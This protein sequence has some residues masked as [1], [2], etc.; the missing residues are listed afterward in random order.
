M[1]LYRRFV[2]PQL[3]DLVMKNE[4]VTGRRAELIPQARGVVL[5]VGVGSWLNLRFYSRAVTR[6]HGVDPS[7]AL[8]EMALAKRGGVSYPVYLPCDSTE[9]LPVASAS[10]DTVVSTWTLCSIPDP[11]AALREMRRV[12]KPSGRFLFVEHG[13]SSDAGVRVWQHRL[14]PLWCRIAGGCN[15]NRRIDELVRSAGFTVDRLQTA[16]LPGPRLMTFTYEGAA[17]R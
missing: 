10:I 3:I 17:S 14:N 15:L 6:L 11:L 9:H 7:P 8:L 5:E 13:L 12:L 4:V 1:G 2:F 16:Y